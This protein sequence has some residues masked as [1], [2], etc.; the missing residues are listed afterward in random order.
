M[1]PVAMNG[2]EQ[3][4]VRSTPKACMV[5]W[6]VPEAHIS[7]VPACNGGVLTVSSNVFVPWNMIAPAISEPSL[8]SCRL[9]CWLML[10]YSDEFSPELPPG[11][12]KRT[13][14]SWAMLRTSETLPIR[15]SGV[16]PRPEP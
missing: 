13:T 11:T 7:R 12:W 2:F 10:T 6:L 16:G 8:H 4:K 1:A 3:L 14:A 5:S 9:A 15:S